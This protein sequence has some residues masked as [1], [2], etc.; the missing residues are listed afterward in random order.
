MDRD[1]AVD[2]GSGTRGKRRGEEESREEARRE[3]DEESG[4]RE[5]GGGMVSSP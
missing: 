3:T 5:R 2:D 4:R 1:P